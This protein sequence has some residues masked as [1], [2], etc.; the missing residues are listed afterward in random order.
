VDPSF[1][2]DIIGQA[3]KTIREIIER[4]DVA[5]DIDKKKGAVKL[6]GKNRDGLK[7]A[8]EHIEGI[9]SGAESTP[10]VEYKVGDVA[11]GIVKKIVDFGAFIELP[12]GVDGLIHISKISDDR[13]QKVSDVLSEGDEMMVEIIEFKGN[14][15]GLARA[16]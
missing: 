5:I 12:G 14:K 16:K 9:I 15:I 3:G 11:K 4:F 7:G 8:R 6:T 1:I 13:V 10:K 2:A